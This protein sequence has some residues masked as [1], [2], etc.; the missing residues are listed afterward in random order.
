MTEETSSTYK[1]EPD[2][3]IQPPSAEL[4]KPES[5]TDIQ[6]SLL[7]VWSLYFTVNQLRCAD[8]QGEGERDAGEDEL[9]I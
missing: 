5:I 9:H 8:R 4:K 7:E 3:L 1:E 6:I 2:G